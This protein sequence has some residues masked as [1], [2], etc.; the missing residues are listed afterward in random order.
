MK[1]DKI[2][3]LRTFI[4]NS[5]VKIYYEYNTENIIVEGDIVI[6]NNENIYS[7]F[8]VKIHK[9]IGNIYWAG[10][11]DQIGIA[12]TLKSLINFPDIVT[13]DVY[14]CKNPSLKSLEGC[15]KEIGG[16]LQFDY[17]NVS[18]ISGI[19]E[20][21]G[22]NCIMNYNPITDLSPMV[23]VQISG[24]VSIVGTPAAKNDKEISYIPD[25]SIIVASES[26]QINYGE[27]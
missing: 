1:N 10:D 14:I 21:I 11:M 5:N 12:G 17:C 18:D 27:N 20:V 19:T 23:N 26:A 9:V 7:Y 15:P 25:S 4:H 13:G 8:P 16:N 3:I 24:I 6:F 22:K 2:D